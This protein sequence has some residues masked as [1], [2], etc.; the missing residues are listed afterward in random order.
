[1]RLRRA[2]VT[3]L[4]ALLGA[5]FAPVAAASG[6]NAAVAVNTKD[7]AA[8]FRLAFSI[9]KVAGDVVDNANGAVAY[10]SCNE[11]RT[12]AL[13]IQ[14]V[15]VTGD[16]EVVTPENVAIA[17]N[18][19][20]TSCET[21]ASAYQFVLGTD[22]EA[23]RFSP[24]GQKAINDIRKELRELGKSGLPVDEI[25]ARVKQLM[26][27]LGAVLKT[28]LETVGKPPENRGHEG[29]DTVETGTETTTPPTTTETETETSPT[30]TAETPP[31]QTTETETEP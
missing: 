30:T 2:I 27:R 26:V 17:I 28:E 15:L 16:P 29:T 7:G 11:C 1:M 21:L 25:Q 4:I 10:A 19:N 31:T 13:A 3:L 22:E 6:D 20:C 14:I 18:E 12:I 5:W 23:V 24:D 9:K 8:V